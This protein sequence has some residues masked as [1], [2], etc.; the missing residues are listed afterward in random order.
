MNVST[1][2]S[3]GTI[4]TVAHP[5]TQAKAIIEINTPRIGKTPVKFSVPPVIT[6]TGD[7][8][9]VHTFIHTISIDR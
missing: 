1:V 5:L 8:I 2:A 9:A 7:K 3:P 6:H 4:E